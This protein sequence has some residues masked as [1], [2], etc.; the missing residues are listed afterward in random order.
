MIILVL[1]ISASLALVSIV[2]NTE[3][4]PCHLLQRVKCIFLLLLSCCDSTRLLHYWDH[5][6]LIPTALIIVAFLMLTFAFLFPRT[7]THVFR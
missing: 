2:S 5:H 7:T 6:L 1:V 4:F 3:L